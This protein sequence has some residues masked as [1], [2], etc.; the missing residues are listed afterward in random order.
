[1]CYD[2]SAPVAASAARPALMPTPLTGGSAAQRRDKHIANVK[3]QR[4]VASR[5]TEATGGLPV[6][7]TTLGG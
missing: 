2:A 3:K 7:D 5:A 4:A 1:V 6:T